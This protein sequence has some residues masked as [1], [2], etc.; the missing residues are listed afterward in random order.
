[1]EEEIDG[2][3][4]GGLIQAR[5]LLFVM[6]PSGKTLSFSRSGEPFVHEKV[7]RDWIRIDEL[8]NQNSSFCTSRN[9]SGI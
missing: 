5:T 6:S 8:Q 7:I 9:M 3:G 1:V 4:E 2:L